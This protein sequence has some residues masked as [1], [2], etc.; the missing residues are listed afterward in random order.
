MIMY[1]DKFSLYIFIY[2]YYIMQNIKTDIDLRNKIHSALQS[3]RPSLSS[4]S[5]RTYSSVLFNLHTKHMKQ[6]H[7][8]IEWF[9]N[10]YQSILDYLNTNTKKSTRK[11]ILSA[12]Y[13]LTNRPEYREQMIA[14]A[15]DINE[16]YRKQKKSQKQKLKRN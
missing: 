9:S 10:Q 5:L 2:L 12:L 15:K 16:E 8:D 4:S 11:S 14:D 6:N 3:Q 1:I 7:N 13:V